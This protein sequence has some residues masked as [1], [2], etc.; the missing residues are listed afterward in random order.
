M[1]I[2]GD[3]FDESHF[4]SWLGR[5]DISSCEN[6]RFIY[7]LLTINCAELRGYIFMHI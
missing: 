7:I 3:Q 4:K 6:C 1:K 5:Y 2:T